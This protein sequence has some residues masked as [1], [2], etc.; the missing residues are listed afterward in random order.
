MN[1]EVEFGV[2]VSLCCGQMGLSAVAVGRSALVSGG[3]CVTSLPATMAA[4]FT[5]PLDNDRSGSGKWLTYTLV[6]KILL[7]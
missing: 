1:T 6:N 5:S 7:C 3:P 2:R 4:L